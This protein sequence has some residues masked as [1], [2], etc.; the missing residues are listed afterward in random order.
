M[1]S[2]EKKV[3]G[4]IL[5]RIRARR[6]ARSQSHL[7]QPPAP[8]SPPAPAK[9]R[10]V[11]FE[12]YEAVDALKRRWGLTSDS[13]E[14]WKRLWDCNPALAQIQTKL[15]SGWVLESDRKI[16][17]YLGNIAF[18]YR[19]GERALTAVT[20]SGF[21]VE[22][23]YRAVSL[24][25]IAAFYRQKSA[26]LFIAT[27]AIESVGKIARAFKSDPLPQ[28]DYETVMFWVL[29]PYPFAKAV[30]KKLDLN[31][32]FLSMA[33][34]AGS[35][36]VAADRLVRRR[37]PRNGSNRL[38]VTDINVADIGEDFGSLWMEKLTEGTRLFADRSPATLRWHF[39]IPGDRGHARVLC[40]REN[41][42]LVGYAVIRNNFNQRNGPQRSIV[43]DMLV[44]NDDPAVIK[45]LL[46]AAYHH[47][48]RSGSHTLELLGFPSNIR[49]VCAEGKPY[50]RKYPAC[51]FFYKAADPALHKTLSAPE[52][53]YGS[54]FDGDA[55]LMP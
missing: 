13:L 8:S 2:F 32:A 3:S 43:A 15:P 53:W 26:D 6:A 52:L 38:L 31:P 27:T 46:V 28:P 34:A 49:K 54:P 4:A 1:S 11:T 50:L 25:L 12:D 21:V 55:T 30:L 37:R 22:P 5:K 17:G 10:E 48:K 42:R 39:G 33:G 20:S 47:A 51:P 19:F 9:L 24:S 45:S 7:E 23:A 41:G 14:N 44:R 29:K 18:L 16:V 36:A 35:V 40:C